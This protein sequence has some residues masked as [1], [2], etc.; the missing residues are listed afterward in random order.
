MRRMLWMILAV[1]VVAAGQG[2]KNLRNTQG[3]CDCN[4]P[5]V[6]SLLQ[7]PVPTANPHVT[8]SSYAMAPQPVTALPAP[9]TA[10]SNL[11]PVIAA[12]NATPGIRISSEPIQVL[13]KIADKP[14]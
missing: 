5:P 4:P 11:P 1:A 8:P 10:V 7:A 14:K 12:P 3:V 9:A 2:C 6:A 13:P